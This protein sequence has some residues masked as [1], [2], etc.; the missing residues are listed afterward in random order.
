MVFGGGGGA[1]DCKTKI[2][3]GTSTCMG[4][5]ILGHELIYSQRSPGGEIIHRKPSNRYDAYFFVWAKRR[6]ETVIL[7][8]IT[9]KTAMCV[10]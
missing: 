6:L 4:Q 10:T 2:E 8:N 7:H 9:F 5:S 3:S 1:L